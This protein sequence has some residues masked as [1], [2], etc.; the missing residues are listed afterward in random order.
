[1]N[2]SGSGREKEDQQEE[3]E[4]KKKRCYFWCQNKRVKEEKSKGSF[5]VREEEEDKK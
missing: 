3:D 4:E 1:M 5:R 2:W